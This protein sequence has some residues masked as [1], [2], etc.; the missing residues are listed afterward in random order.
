MIRQFPA[1]GKIYRIA[2]M[3]IITRE[4]SSE[5]KVAPFFMRQ[6]ISWSSNELSKKHDN[7]ALKNTREFVCTI[8]FALSNLILRCFTGSQM[9]IFSKSNHRVRLNVNM[10]T[11]YSISFYFNFGWSYHFVLRIKQQIFNKARFCKLII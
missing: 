11:A 8:H 1:I 6:A 9:T 5:E 10:N 2:S 4:M 3:F 7:I